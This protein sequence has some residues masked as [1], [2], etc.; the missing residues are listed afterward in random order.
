MI[1]PTSNLNILYI[2][3]S[4]CFSVWLTAILWINTSQGWGE[5][6]PLILI[7]VN[8]L[9]IIEEKLSASSSRATEQNCSRGEPNMVPNCKIFCYTHWIAL[10]NRQDFDFRFVRDDKN[11]PVTV[12]TWILRHCRYCRKL[13]NRRVLLSIFLP[14][15]VGLDNGETIILGW[16]LLW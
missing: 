3:I 8:S 5:G 15:L 11:I 16:R 14:C 7:S 2:F 4:I 13:R 10:Q 9:W 1:G 6:G 12:F